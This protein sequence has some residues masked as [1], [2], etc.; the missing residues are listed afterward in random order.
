MSIR[1]GCQDARNY[2]PAALK[3]NQNGHALYDKAQKMMSNAY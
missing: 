2:F 1:I 3:G